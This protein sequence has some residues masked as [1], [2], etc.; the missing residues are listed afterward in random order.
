MLLPP[1]IPNSSQNRSVGDILIGEFSPRRDAL[2][3]YDTEGLATR[4]ADWESQLPDQLRKTTPDGSL[5][6][7][8]WASMLQFSYQYG[9]NSPLPVINIL[10]VFRNCL[11]LLFRPKAIENLSPSE[12][13]CDVRG[14]MAADT[15]T[16]LAEDLLGAGMIK[17][18]LIHLY[19]LDL[20]FPA[21]LTFCPNLL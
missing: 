11:I 19:D 10:I 5:G 9:S 13:E 18:G 2:D 3:K 4:L 7:S 20:F 21:Q 6:A 8:F 14:R 15:I 16:R 1:C 12:A 17:L